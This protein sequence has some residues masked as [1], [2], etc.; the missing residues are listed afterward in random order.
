M[1][2]D[3]DVL[4]ELHDRLIT[5]LTALTTGEDW[6]GFLA[7][8][9]RFHRYSPNN[10]L[11]LAMQGATGHVAGYARWQ[12]VPAQGGGHCQVR[13]GEK[14]LVVLAPMMGTRRERDDVT[15]TE[16]I[17]E[18]VVRGFKAAKVFHQGQLVAP[19]DLP[20]APVPQLLTGANRWQ[21]IWAAVTAHLEASGYDIELVTVAPHETWN[22]RTDFTDYRVEIRD[23]LEPPARIKTLL[24]E[25][26]H[27]HLGHDHRLTTERELREV[28]AE[29]TAYLLCATIGLNSAG[30]SVPYVAGWAAGNP[31]LLRDTAEQVLAATATMIGELEHELGIELTTDPLDPAQP[32]SVEALHDRATLNQPAPQ[33]PSPKGE[34]LVDRV[35]GEVRT[36]LA[37]LADETARAGFMAA[38]NHRDV[39]SNLA[40]VV[41]GCRNAGFD[42]ARTATFLYTTGGVDP[43]RVTGAILRDDDDHPPRASGAR[44]RTLGE[45][46]RRSASDALAAVA[47]ASALRDKVLAAIPEGDRDVLAV[48]DV[49][50]QDHAEMAAVMLAEGGVDRE[51]TTA[52]LQ[53]LGAT[54]ATV[55][56][57]IDQ[58]RYNAAT[59]RHEPLWTTNN[60]PAPTR[61]ATN[62][63][64]PPGRQYV[65]PTSVVGKLVE[66]G[67]PARLAEFADSS[68]LNPGEAVALWAHLGVEVGLA[69]RTTLV[70]RG[71][72]HAAAINDLEQH[73][74]APAPDDWA[75]HLPEPEPASTTTRI[76]QGWRRQLAATRSGG[77]PPEAWSHRL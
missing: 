45:Q 44:R 14:A 25:W 70:R 76:L 31:D 56:R 1:P 3:S 38:W 49:N 75:E 37:A 53:A 2:G 26:A 32:A 6:L 5:Q 42:I 43:D 72:D 18:R 39:E 55:T 68:G 15:G 69:A 28:E 35:G 63:A 47:A 40:R 12:R 23:D 51:H 52:V 71:G 13:R 9:R 65:I 16:Q 36:V 8:S 77:H 17:V 62:P 19:P 33:Q 7:A 66:A 61:P 67:N 74:N 58:K 10:Q 20:E 50:R 24:H 48:L 41:E 73:W 64:A 29:S 46:V 59:S 34:S 22:G 27:I 30:Y 54:P 4:A 21:H 11:L 60:P 57:A